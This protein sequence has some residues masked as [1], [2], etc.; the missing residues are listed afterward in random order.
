MTGTET[1]DLEAKE[2]VELQGTRP[3]LGKRR[4]LPHLSLFLTDFT[5][6]D[7]AQIRARA[8]CMPAPVGTCS[9]HLTLCTCVLEPVPLSPSFCHTVT[10][11]LVGRHTLRFTTAVSRHHFF[12]FSMSTPSGSDEGKYWN[13]L[14]GVERKETCKNTNMSKAS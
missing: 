10:H 9:K 12:S 1:G 4:N 3:A 13:P 6:A 8:D 7:R 2:P 5:I 11:R 14:V